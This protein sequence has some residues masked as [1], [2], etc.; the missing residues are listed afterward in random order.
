MV[1]VQ[2]NLILRTKSTE[3]AQSESKQLGITGN[4]LFDRIVGANIYTCS[5]GEYGRIG[6]VPLVQRLC[7]YLEESSSVDTRRKKVY[8]IPVGGSNGLGTWGYIAAVEEIMTQSD[9]IGLTFDHVV[10]ASGSGGTAAGISLGMILAHHGFLSSTPNMLPHIHAVGVCDNPDYFYKTI[11]EIFNEMGLS[12]QPSFTENLLRKYLTVHQGKGLG[13]GFSTK[14][15]LAFIAQFAIETG[16]ALDPVYTGKALYHFIL[17]V[18]ENG[19]QE[20]YR[21]STILFW[22]TGGG[23]GIFE[24]GDS[25]L[26]ILDKQSSVQKLDVYGKGNADVISI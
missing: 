15:E 18:L 25:L 10:V 9:D 11:L 8:E 13:Y 2:P 17:K 5:P 26:D 1:G 3:T 6:S 14:E 12:L 22:H 21:N 24:K 16:I 4:I 19:N 20:V 7:R 23:L